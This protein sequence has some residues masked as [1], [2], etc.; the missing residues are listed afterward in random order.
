[1]KISSVVL[2]Y[3]TP[4]SLDHLETLRNYLDV[5]S[6]PNHTRKPASIMDDEEEA[7][8]KNVIVFEEFVKE[9]VATL[10]IQLLAGKTQVDYMKT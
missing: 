8:L 4:R 10:Q 2:N 5:T 1:M 6:I 7:L 9:L 3:S